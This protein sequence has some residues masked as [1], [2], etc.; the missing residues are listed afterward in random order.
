MHA[1]TYIIYLHYTHT[2]IHVCIR[3][4]PAWP[5]LPASPTSPLSPGIP[6]GPGLQTPGPVSSQIR[7]AR[8]YLNIACNHKPVIWVIDVACVRISTCACV[9]TCIIHICVYTH[10]NEHIS[11]HTCTYMHA[12]TRYAHDESMHSHL[13]QH[14]YNI[15]Q[16]HTTKTNKHTQIHAYTPSSRSRRARPA[17]VSEHIRAGQALHANGSRSALVALRSGLAGETDRTC[18]LGRGKS[19]N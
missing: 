6:G 13:Q 9:G 15:P 14:T 3:Y 12:C 18:R 2:Y 16:S 7:Q 8:D 10:T 1:Y 19:G 17:F 4:L 11:T 5:I